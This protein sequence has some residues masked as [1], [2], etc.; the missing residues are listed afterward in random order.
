MVDESENQSIVDLNVRSCGDVTLGLL[1]RHFE[2]KRGLAHAAVMSRLRFPST[3]AE[4][5]SRFDKDFG[6]GKMIV[7]AWFYDE[8][9]N[10]GWAALV[11][12]AKDEEGLGQFVARVRNLEVK[13]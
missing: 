1:R 11:L 8:V 7:V 12:G 5:F 2:R 10:V 6:A 4:L 9:E 13:D 3:R